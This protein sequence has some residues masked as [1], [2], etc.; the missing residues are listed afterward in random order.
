MRFLAPLNTTSATLSTGPLPV[1]GGFLTIPADIELSDGDR[2]GL[3]ANGFTPAPDETPP[4]S[5]VVI[6][7]PAAVQPA[8]EESTTRAGRGAKAEG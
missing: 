2:L 1:E 7:Q 3:V 4:A 8:E 6:D 5:A